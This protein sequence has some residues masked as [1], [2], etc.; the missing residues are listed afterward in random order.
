MASFL[1]KLFGFSGGSKEDA[2]A[3]GGGKT[4]S[5]ADCLIRAT[6]QREGAQFRLAGSVEKEADGVTRV[7]TFIRADLFS[8]EQDVIDATLRKGRQIIDQHGPSLFSD[9]AVSRQV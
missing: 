9:E 1:S 5:Y 3:S 6:P 7:R 2:N 8:S 4:E